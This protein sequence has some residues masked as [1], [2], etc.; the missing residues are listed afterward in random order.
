M[1]PLEQVDWQRNGK[2][3]GTCTG[4]VT[5][6]GL[7]ACLAMRECGGNLRKD[8]ANALCN[9]GVC[10]KRFCTRHKA[11]EAVERLSIELDAGFSAGVSNTA[12]RTG[13]TRVARDIASRDNLRGA[14]SD[15]GAPWMNDVRIADIDRGGTRGLRIA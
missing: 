15:V 10:A 11:V 7:S 13:D 9:Q 6:E 3:K 4:G 12:K 5:N 14:A 1:Y 2:A 8:K